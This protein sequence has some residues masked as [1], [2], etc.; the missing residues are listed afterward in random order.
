MKIKIITLIITTLL[1]QGVALVNAQV[2]DTSLSATDPQF[3]YDYIGGSDGR[4]W[5]GHG[6]HDQA[7]IYTLGD[8]RTTYP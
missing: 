3:I 2:N 5:G 7:Q 1:F 6:L 8:R 4:I